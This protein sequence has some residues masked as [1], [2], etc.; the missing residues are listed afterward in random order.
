MS[1]YSV[2]IILSIMCIGLG[3]ILFISFRRNRGRILN[4]FLFNALLML[5]AVDI[6]AFSFTH[7]NPFLQAISLL[8]MILGI[9]VFLL[10]YYILI[11]GLFK[12]CETFNPERRGS[13]FKFINAF[14]RY[15]FNFLCLYYSVTV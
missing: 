14:C 6:I 10:G 8:L 12:K 7:Y 15:R 5:I 2:V 4:G 13:F 9:L 3:G 1:D 11:I